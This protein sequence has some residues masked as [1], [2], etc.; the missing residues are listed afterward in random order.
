MTNT[1][2]MNTDETTNN[3]DNQ[4][5]ATVEFEELLY[6]LKRKATHDGSSWI[7]K[8]PR[9]GGEASVET[10]GDGYYPNPSTAPIHVNFRE[11]IDPVW[12]QPP[13][14]THVYA[15]D[16]P[17]VPDNKEEWTT[18]DRDKGYEQLDEARDVWGDE[19]KGRVLGENTVEWVTNRRNKQYPDI[20]IE[21][22]DE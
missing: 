6:G 11:F 20:T 5:H 12:I 21:V 13:T 8:V 15:E 22:V 18:D 7:V 16:V 1:D 17:D 9:S 10:D 4:I 2:N 3:T 19:V 14:M